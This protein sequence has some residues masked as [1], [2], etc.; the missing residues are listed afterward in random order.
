M[1]GNSVFIHMQVFTIRDIENLTGIKAHTLR[2][3][4][5]RYDL[6]TPRRKESQ[7]RIYDNEDLKQ[8]LRIS[9][10][11]HSGMKVSKIAALSQGQITELVNQATVGN[12]NYRVF[13]NQLIEAA[14]DFD[15][16]RFIGILNQVTE[17]IGFENCVV[18]L[19]YPFL[20]KIGLLWSTNNVI[21]AQEHFTSYII[22]NKIIVETEKLEVGNTLPSIVL[23]SP[24][25]EFHELPLLFINYLLKKAGW[26]T[27]YLGSNIQTMEA[28]EVVNRVGMHYLY[29]H[30][31]TNFTGL[32]IDDYFESVCKTF[33]NK[34]IVAS[35]EAIQKVQRSFVNLI[36]LRTKEQ[37]Y[38]F[39]RKAK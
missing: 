6:F 12:M 3:W 30:T 23:M 20:V 25:G 22:Q 8:L 2:I 31:L 39:I 10:L 14:L 1:I 11:Y 13:I 24:K 4:E 38:D 16:N 26:A 15:E 28:A 27:V 36:L 21:P 33:T 9:F 7:H 29:I 17:K 5:Q 18:D 19:C 34:K 37:I 32:D 35:G